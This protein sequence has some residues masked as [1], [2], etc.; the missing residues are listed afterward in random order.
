MVVGVSA[1]S[2]LL[3]VTLTL[4]DENGTYAPEA[5]GFVRTSSGNQVSFTRA[6][7]QG[8]AASYDAELVA[9]DTAGNATTPVRSPDQ[10]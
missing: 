10:R 4:T 9:T 7:A 3:D 2:A 8:E 5:V 1:D 6:I